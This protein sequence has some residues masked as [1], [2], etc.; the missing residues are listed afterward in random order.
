MRAGPAGAAAIVV[1]AALVT[2]AMPAASSEPATGNDGPEG[3]PAAKSAQ[4]VP[5]LPMR[6]AAAQ[7]ER[8][9][10]PG[11]NATP[12]NSSATPATGAQSGAAA[13]GSLPFVPP[14]PGR[15]PAPPPPAA[16]VGAAPSSS[17]AAPAAGGSSASAARSGPDPRFAP[18]RL[19]PNPTATPPAQPF[20]PQEPPQLSAQPHLGSAEPPPEPTVLQQLP[21]QAPP[22]GA[23]LPPPQTLDRTVTASAATGLPGESVFT[24]PDGQGFRIL[25]AG[26]SDQ[27]TQAGGNLLSGL[28]RRML[29]QPEL[30]MQ[31]RAFAAGT[32]DTASQARR[33]SLNRA[34]AVRSLL[35]DRGVPSTRI[36]VRALGN[37]APEPATTPAPPADRV[38]L[39]LTN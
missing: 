7:P 34:L 33:L 8:S 16:T 29:D 6:L 4:S 12:D 17:T 10:P 28:A 2:L 25:F 30:R 5:A 13:A 26:G 21:P 32:A 19:P 27:L 36:D 14:R 35:I 20:T 9:A 18:L 38:D 39:V 1:A 22:E 3:R 15:K 31:I 24:L 37:T 11:A 23:T